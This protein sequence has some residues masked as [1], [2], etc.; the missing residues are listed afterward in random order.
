[1][2]NY[3]PVQSTKKN[4]CFKTLKNYVEGTMTLSFLQRTTMD[5][6]DSINLLDYMRL[7]G[8]VVKSRNFLHKTGNARRFQQRKF[9][10]LLLSCLLLLC[11][12]LK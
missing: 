5:D 4:G 1:M 8:T 6:L 9:K 2:L 10:Y 3:H 12:N 7:L 11:V